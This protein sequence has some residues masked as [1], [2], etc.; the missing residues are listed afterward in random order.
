MNIYMD[1]GDGGGGDSRG[2][3]QWARRVSQQVKLEYKWNVFVEFF[4]DIAYEFHM[5]IDGRRRRRRH[6]HRHLANA[7]WFVVENGIV[8]EQQNYVT[9]WH[10]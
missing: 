10:W 7:S 6:C 1:D 9:D 4:T 2:N 8:N 3:G 5:A